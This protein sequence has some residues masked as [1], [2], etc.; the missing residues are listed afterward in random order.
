MPE[1]IERLQGID[2]A[3]DLMQPFIRD[4]GCMSSPLAIGVELQ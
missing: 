3:D 1:A 4:L 2:D